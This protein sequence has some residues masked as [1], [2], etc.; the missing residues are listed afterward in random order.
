MYLAEHI[1][2]III[3][4]SI[5]KDIMR[6]AVINLLVFLFFAINTFNAVGSPNW[7]MDIKSIIVGIIR[8]YNP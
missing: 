1:K 7:E 5:V 4:K 2:K 6:D 3:N 8:A